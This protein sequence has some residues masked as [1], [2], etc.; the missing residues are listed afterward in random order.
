MLIGA[1][2]GAGNG[3][4]TI[5]ASYLWGGPGRQS[6]EKLISE[7]NASQ[8]HVKVIGVSSPDSQKAAHVDVLVQRFL[9]H[10]RQ[11]RQRGRRMGIRASLLR[12]PATF[13]PQHR[14][15]SDFAPS[16]VSQMKGKLHRRLLHT[17]PRGHSVMGAK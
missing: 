8:S 6:L 2:A 1:G 7:Y 14:H 5:T 3:K 11:L 17:H 10:L 4:T 13:R 15:I 16:A 12:L 9:R